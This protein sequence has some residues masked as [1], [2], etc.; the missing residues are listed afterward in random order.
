MKKQ[1]INQQENEQRNNGQQKM[2]M[3]RNK[4]AMELPEIK[5]LSPREVKLIAWLEFYQKYFFSSKDIKHFFINKATLYKGIKKLL[6]KK[7]IIK[8]AQNRYYLVPIKAKSGI[9]SE[10]PFI[11]I[12]EIFNLEVYYIGGWS[13]ANYWKLTDQVPSWIDVFSTAK[14]GRKEVLNIKI[15]FHRVRKIDKSKYIL[16]KI[17][18]HEFKILSKKES[19]RW[20]KSKEYL[21]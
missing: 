20:M 16:K 12:D 6:Q 11:V 9:W 15:I 19:A 1:R 4:H 8:L 3:S 13:A 18:G 7:R 5:G 21:I 10:H 17:K 2:S 14:Q